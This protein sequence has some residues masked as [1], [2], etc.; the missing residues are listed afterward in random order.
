[1]S[2]IEL[3]LEGALAVLL[4]ACLFYCWRLDRRLAALRSGQDG[5]RA[6][7]AELNGSVAAAEK[8]IRALRLTAQESGADLQARIDTAHQISER[9]GLA[10]GRLRS[11]A[12]VG[13]SGRS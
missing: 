3:A 4:A 11:G 13:R 1:M 6:A 7:A 2:P 9:L 10:L 5:I 8:A 12:D